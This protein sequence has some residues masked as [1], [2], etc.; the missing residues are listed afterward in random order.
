MRT[1]ASVRPLPVWPPRRFAVL[2]LLAATALTA[3]AAQAGPYATEVSG[4]RWN[5]VGGIRWNEVGA[6]LWTDTAGIRWNEVGGIRWNEVG[7]PLFSDSSGIRWNEVGGIRWNE[8]GALE[9]VNP[10]DTGPATVGLDLLSSLAALPDTST[11]DV[12]VTYRAMPGG[13]DLD[14]LTALG[15]SGGMIFQQLPMVVV[16]A[17]K[18]QVAAIAALPAVRSVYANR[19]LSFFDDASGAA[20]GLDELAADPEL[21]LTG[22]LA[23]S[24]AG[25]TIAVLD[26]GIDGE[27]PDL[28]F[29]D[30][31]VQNVRLTGELT[32]VVGFSYPTP[33][34]DIVDTDQLLGH[35]TFV[36]SVAA[37]DG[38]ASSGLY[39]GVAPGASL[40]GLSAGDLLIL[41]VLE[42]FDYILDHAAAHGVRIVNCSWGTQGWFDPDDPVNVATRALWDAGIIAVFAAGN[43]GPAQDTLNPYAVAPWVIGAGAT[44]NSGRLA[45]FS[46][47]G[48]YEELLYHP[49]LVAP[50]RAIVGAKAGA[51]TTVD[52][53]AGIV[54]PTMGASVPPWHAAHYTVSSG[55]SFAAPHVAGVIALMLEADPGLTPARI[56]RLLQ[57]TA[58]PSTAHDRSRIGAGR[59][60]AWA[61]LAALLDPARRFGSHV[62]AWLDERPYTVEHRP[63]V[64]LEATVPA[65]GALALPVTLEAGTRS[66]ALSLAWSGVPGLADLDVRLLDASGVELARAT[67]LN[68][69]GVFGRTEGLRLAGVLPAELTAEVFFK[70]GT[71]TF[72]QPVSI[73]TETAVVTLHAWGDLDGLAPAE[74]HAVVEA[75]SRNLIAGR[76]DGFEPSAALTRGEL[77]RSLAWTAGA[78]QRIPG[79]RSFDDLGPAHVEHPWVEAV[80]G[81]RAGR[82]MIEPWASGEFRADGR[83]RRIDFAAAL[84]RA[85]GLAAQAEGLAGVALGLADDA[86]IPARLRGYALLALDHGF[87]EPIDGRFEPTSSV[88]RVEA[89]RR[90]VVLSDL[91]REDATSSTPAAAGVTDRRRPAAAVPPQ[92]R[93]RAVLPSPRPSH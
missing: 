86:A 71:G 54:D 65:G 21:R 50:G 25:V 3:P 77:A 91:V 34:E 38:S 83:V 33:I 57:E 11:I 82:M 62:P 12:V 10:T 52:G 4:I 58:T 88:P 49:T 78:T 64:E 13:A 42:G 87:I 55:T 59:L 16:N 7:G 79:A 63:A 9:L 60:D 44:D 93:S 26:T 14:Q 72:A 37:G 76:G 17:T 92:N 30:K 35:G 90:L 24:G 28:A 61:A 40:L 47:R 73:R 39:A 66:F 45:D 67:T 85:A 8:V 22:D 84:V 48:V 74:R 23:V 46:S 29:G 20:I 5:E 68:G 27:H 69:F 81:R 51:V 36:A 6:P 41:N 18:Q 53:I 80:A 19:T 15:I 31:L 89:A 43:H 1:C 32:G 75:A 70:P 56:R 2:L